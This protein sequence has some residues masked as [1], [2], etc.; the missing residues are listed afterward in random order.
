M[1]IY[2][3]N[4]GWFILAGWWII[5]PLLCYLVYFY[6]GIDTR[7]HFVLCFGLQ[8]A[9]FPVTLVFVFLDRDIIK[10]FIQRCKDG[11]VF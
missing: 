4:I 6:T 11:D 7:A 3:I 2:E 5:P 1:K 9:G 8:G 10:D